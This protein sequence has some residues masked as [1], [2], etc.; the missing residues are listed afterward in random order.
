MLLYWINIGMML[1]HVQGQTVKWNN[2]TKGVSRWIK[3]LTARGVQ[4]L[5]G[6]SLAFSQPLPPPPK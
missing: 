1:D 2:I 3:N 6:Q 5:S 4:F